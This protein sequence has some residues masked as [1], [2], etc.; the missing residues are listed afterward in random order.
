VELPVPRKN[1]VQ[2][3]ERLK[4]AFFMRKKRA[5]N[6]TEKNHSKIDFKHTIE[7]ILMSCLKMSPTAGRADAMLASSTLNYAW[8]VCI[9]RILWVCRRNSMS[10]LRIKNAFFMH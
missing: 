10:A 1:R 5:K 4:N 9:P 3:I 8:N 2:R 6:A 7:C